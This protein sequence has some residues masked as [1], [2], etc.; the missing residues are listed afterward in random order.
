MNTVYN[1]VPYKGATVKGYN[2]NTSTGISITGLSGNE[3]CVCS[4]LWT[5]IGGF[6]YLSPAISTATVQISRLVVT[7]SFSLTSDVTV[8]T[9]LEDITSIDVDKLSALSGKTY[10]F[11]SSPA[12]SRFG[13][14]AQE[15]ERVYPNLVYT[16][17]TTGVKTIDYIGIIP[18]ITEKLK[19][20][21]NKLAEI[22]H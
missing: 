10:S 12:T 17:K 19:E 5:L 11:I 13:Y 9:N 21:D 14:V 7:D 6:V 4:N 18:I 2:S 20:I 16:D 3:P 8:K 1:K 15:M 22:K